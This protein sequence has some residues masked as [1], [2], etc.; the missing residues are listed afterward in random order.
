MQPP[1]LRSLGL[2][3]SLVVSGLL[4]GCIARHEL[5]RARS[6][7]FDAAIVP[8]CPTEADGAV[9]RCQLSRALYAAHLFSSGQVRV[10][11][12]SGSAVHNPF[13]EALGMA[14][15]M[16][17]AGVPADHIYLEPDALH[18]DENM[19][20]SLRIARALGLRDLAVVSQR[21]HAAWGCRMME[22]WG[23]SCRSLPVDL[24]VVE[25]RHQTYAE[26]L[27][28]LRVPTQPHWIELDERERRRARA[29]GRR[30][31]PS[32]L[33]Y[34]AM[35][36]MRSNGKPWVPAAAGPPDVLTLAE[37]QRAGAASLPLR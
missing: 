2:A 14:M 34:P 30:R 20:F 32:Y 10:L 7:P 11:I 22:D 8:G 19:Y 37:M 33:L 4:S 31:P 5:R 28:G 26:A 25:A 1:S 6:Q 21:G 13:S 18:T 9:S 29:V 12:A 15:A 16:A 24:S 17:G 36:V 27:R 35:G 3:L 23:Q